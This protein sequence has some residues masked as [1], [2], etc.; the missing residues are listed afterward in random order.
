L[1]VDGKGGGLGARVPELEIEYYPDQVLFVARGAAPFQLAYGHHAAPPTSFSPSE[2]LALLPT[3][4]R[5]QLLH[6]DTSCSP[7]RS[8]AGPAAFKPPPPPPPLKRYALWSV[9]I[10]ATLV[11]GVS[12][13]RL[14]RSV[15]KRDGDEGGAT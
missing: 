2:I 15:A 10:L 3:A 8:R 14:S 12:A 1:R 5:D 7:P 13:F 6:P 9:L 11:L 4:Q